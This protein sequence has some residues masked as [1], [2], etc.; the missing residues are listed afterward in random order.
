VASLVLL[1][2]SSV[3]LA[4]VPWLGAIVSCALLVAVLPFGRDAS[5]RFVLLLVLLVGL[6]GV[7]LLIGRFLDV[8][9]LS[10][11]RLRLVML[12]PALSATALVAAAAARRRRARWARP[13]ALLL[14][15]LVVPVLARLRSEERRVG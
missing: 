11:D 6:L 3:L 9:V 15:L 7:G 12:L 2:A 5:S 10:P 4:T 13:D 14:P 8:R 1:V